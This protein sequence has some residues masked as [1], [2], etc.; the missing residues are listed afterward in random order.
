[1][2]ILNKAKLGVYLE[3]IKQLTALL[4]IKSV[5]LNINKTEQGNVVMQ[6]GKPLYVQLQIL[7]DILVK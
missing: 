1:L 7:V 4:K 3:K 5:K 6:T 2:T